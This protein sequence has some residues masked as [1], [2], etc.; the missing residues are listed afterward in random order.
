MGVRVPILLALVVVLEQEAVVEALAKVRSAD[1]G[2]HEHDLGKQKVAVHVR[3][4]HVREAGPVLDNGDD[5]GLV[6]S[7]GVLF[8]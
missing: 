2:T 1:A 8:P 7:V 4:R 6:R 3:P 5:G